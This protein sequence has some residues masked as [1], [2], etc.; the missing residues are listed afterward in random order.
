MANSNNRDDQF[1]QDTRI[2]EAMLCG[3][4]VSG[5]NSAAPASPI[6][7]RIVKSPVA[8]LRGCQQHAALKRRPSHIT[9]GGGDAGL[10]LCAAIMHIHFMRYEQCFARLKN[11]GFT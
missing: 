7:A 9:S 1:G 5:R 10:C 4:A 2:T 11:Q 6:V 3:G 8:P